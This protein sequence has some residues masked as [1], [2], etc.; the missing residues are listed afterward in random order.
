M[1]IG[2][3]ELMH[4]CFPKHSLIRTERMKQDKEIDTVSMERS[5]AGTKKKSRQQ[6]L[7]NQNRIVINI[8]W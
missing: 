8:I 7:P 4:V 3:E 5:K 6:L 1:A 2:N